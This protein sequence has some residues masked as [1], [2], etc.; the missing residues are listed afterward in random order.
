MSSYFFSSSTDE[1]KLPET[2]ENDEFVTTDR[3]DQQ[4]CTDNSTD[5]QYCTEIPINLWIVTVDGIP[6]GYDA[7]ENTARALMLKTGREIARE[8][9]ASPTFRASIHQVDDHRIDVL[10]SYTV[11]IVSYD[12][13]I[14]SIECHPCKPIEKI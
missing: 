9:N 3:I 4:Y 10:G 12:S 5:Q 6:I 13:C 2:I 1:D 14:A 11:F 8:E 7:D